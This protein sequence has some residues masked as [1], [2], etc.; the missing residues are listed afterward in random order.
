MSLNVQNNPQSR[1]IMGL[2]GES[3]ST[4]IDGKNGKTRGAGEGSLNPSGPIPDS[5]GGF[6]INLKVEANMTI[7][8]DDLPA[9]VREAVM[10]VLEQ[11]QEL[12]E[13]SDYV[14]NNPD[15]QTAIEKLQALL[16]EV[17]SDDILGE[18]LIQFASMA[19]ENALDTE[20]ASIKSKQALLQVAVTETIEA[21]NKI[22]EAAIITASVGLASAGVSLGGAA[23]SSFELGKSAT[24]V[25]N[26]SKA[27]TTASAMQEVVDKAKQ[28]GD[29]LDPSVIRDIKNLNTKAEGLLQESKKL[30]TFA[31]TVQQV[32]SS[33]GKI[34]ESGASLESSRLEAD[35]RLDEADKLDAQALAEEAA[36]L[37]EQAASLR[38]ELLDL[39]KSVLEFLSAIKQSRAELMHTFTKV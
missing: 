28:A 1:Q 29:A 13:L 35:A 26:A 20:L 25:K 24:A 36:A 17:R 37:K 11:S 32:S 2:E 3:D 39:I 8:L 23:F 27:S 34:M 9:E 22:R 31:D 30:S 38:A 18:L 33:T 16:A 14:A 6:S 10:K 21:A 7:T 19:R 15:D 4:K 12:V 5:D